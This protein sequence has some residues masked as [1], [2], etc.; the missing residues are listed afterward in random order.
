MGIGRLTRLG[1]GAALVVAVLA[2]CG[3]PSQVGSAMIVGD[4][5]VALADVQSSIDLAL[6][7]RADITAQAGQDVADSDIA[8]YVVS[9]ETTHELLASAAARAGVSVGEDA[10]DAA[11]ANQDDQ[12]L[13]LD[14][15]LFTGEAL[16]ERARDRELAI[17]LAEKYVDRL[18]VTVDVAAATSREDADAKARVLAAGG[19]EAD[20]LLADPRSGQAGQTYR[21][22]TDPDSATTVVFGVPAGSVVSFQ[23]S[24]GQG[25]W[26]VVRVAQRTTD[27]AADGA[28]AGGTIDRSTLASIG[29]RLAQPEG[30]PVEVNPRFGV[31]DPVRMAV[32]APGQESGSVLSPS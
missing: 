24:P 28:P 32:V 19:P 27:A 20:R 25:F 17:A 2:G 16:R 26:L 9:R 18:A 1:G 22:A 12:S 8:R 31:W 21:A 4:R 13:R 15:I 3:A 23:P 14:R 29:E 6:A 11:L 10:V 5:T 7:H 30:G